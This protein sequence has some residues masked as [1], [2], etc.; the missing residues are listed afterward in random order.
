MSF[1]AHLEHLS[2]AAIRQILGCRLPYHL[3]GGDRIERVSP[4]E[5]C[6]GRQQDSAVTPSACCLWRTSIPPTIVGT[7]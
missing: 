5:G 2:P 7:R 1:P 6:E 3:I 4:G